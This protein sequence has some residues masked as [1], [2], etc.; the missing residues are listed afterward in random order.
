MIDSSHPENGNSLG[1]AKCFQRGRTAFIK[2][3]ERTMGESVMS[4]AGETAL[5]H[6]TLPLLWICLHR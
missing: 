2:R 4:W 5:D 1:S 3:E 6:G